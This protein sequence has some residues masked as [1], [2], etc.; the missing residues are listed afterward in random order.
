M[1]PSPL[2][3]PRRENDRAF[4]TILH[5]VRTTD[6]EVPL[7]RPAVARLVARSWQAGTVMAREDWGLD[8][9]RP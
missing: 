3:G 4:L 7:A 2:T 6:R 9:P 1:N 5:A 8:R